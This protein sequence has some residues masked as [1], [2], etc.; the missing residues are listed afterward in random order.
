MNVRSLASLTSFL[1]LVASLTLLACGGDDDTADISDD[2]S[3]T[4]GDTAPA[5]SDALSD[6]VTPPSS[7]QRGT[8]EPDFAA[9]PLAGVAVDASGL[10]PGRYII[11]STYLQLDPDARPTFDQLIQPILADLETRDGLLALSLG[12]SE[13]C[14]ALRTLGVWRDDAAMIAFVTSPAHTAAMTRVTDISR[15]GSVVT[16]WLGDETSASWEA[17]VEEV[18]AVEQVY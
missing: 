5:V 4:A 11:S 16:H 18:R 2:P 1:P 10:R 14:V 9:A 17:A 15:G 13:S 12:Q 8:L 3:A 7:C 6:A